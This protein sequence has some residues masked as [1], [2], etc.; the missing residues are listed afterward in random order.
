MNTVINN[1]KSVWAVVLLLVLAPFALA[2]DTPAQG[3]HLSFATPEE[4]VDALITALETDN[5]SR[6]ASLLGPGTEDILSSGDT[7]Q[8]S[9]DRAAFLAGVKSKHSLA[10][11]GDERTLL[12]GDKDW[13]FPIPVMRFEDRWYLDGDEGA[14]EMVYRRI[15]RNE[16]GAIAVCRGFVDAQFDYAA[17]GHDG[18]DAGI[19]ALKLISDEGLHNG[20]YWPTVE[21]EELSP[22]GEFVAN[23]S[24]EGYRQGEE[25]VPYHGYFYRMLYHQGVD[26]SGGVSDY[27][28]DG[29][30]TN[31][32]ALIAWP[33][34]YGVSGVMTFMVN[35]DGVVYQKDLGDDTQAQADAIN[36]FN[37]DNSWSAL[38][39]DDSEAQ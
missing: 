30:L 37:P 33:A 14:D 4:A 6:L 29:L 26:A 11:E 31:G 36:V 13:P 20:L 23:A 10:G 25:K 24:A 15:G 3:E 27:F 21:G 12:V 16:L 22:A 34:D 19:Y 38:A 5:K 28:K 17:E 7:Q 18:D 35:Q 9:A 39:D 1:F 2:T 32:F 8:D